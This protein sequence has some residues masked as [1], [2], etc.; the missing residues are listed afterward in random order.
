MGDPDAV[1]AQ[2]GKPK[3][4]QC[5]GIPGPVQLCMHLAD[6]Y[7]CPDTHSTAMG[8]APQVREMELSPPVG[9]G[10]VAMMG[11]AGTPAHGRGAAEPMPA[12]SAGQIGKQTTAAGQARKQV[13]KCWPAHLLPPAQRLHSMVMQWWLRD[14]G[15]RQP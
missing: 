15:W 8:T 4:N 13:N 9:A 7:A 10:L 6:A 1:A 14:R 11:W 5:Q 3:W 12:G 2:E